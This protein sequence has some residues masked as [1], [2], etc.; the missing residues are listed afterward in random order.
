MICPKCKFEQPASESCTHC[1]IIF[2]RYKE[3][4][5]RK[6]EIVKEILPSRAPQNNI[7]NNILFYSMCTIFLS[8]II[9]RCI[10]FREFPDFLD[11]YFRLLMLGAMGWLAF[12]I[13]PRAAALFTRLDAETDSKQGLD[14]FNIYDKKAIFIFSALSLFFI[15]ALVWAW[16]SGSI[17]CFAG[18]GRTCHEI[19]DSLADP[20]A[21]WA[22][23]LVYFII[24]LFPTVTVFMGL[25][26]RRNRKSEI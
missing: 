23:A 22:T 16:I 17:E 13:V 8:V 7:G 1:G 2:S 12:G 15:V 4:Q 26:M 21:F 6:K 14:G 19:Y 11:P 25:Q 9:A 20:G 5:E 24:A 18:K 3:A 10:Y